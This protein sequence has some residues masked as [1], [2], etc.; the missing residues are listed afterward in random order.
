M[1]V[2][3][4]TRIAVGVLF[5]VGAAVAFAGVLPLDGTLSMAV[6][7]VDLLIG[8]GLLVSAGLGAGRP[9]EPRVGTR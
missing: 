3:D 7:V 2:N 4:S 8:L 9:S 5:V 1:S 6:G